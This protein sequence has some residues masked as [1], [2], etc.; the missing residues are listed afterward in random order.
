MTTQVKAQSVP[1]KEAAVLLERAPLGLLGELSS[2]QQ[3]SVRVAGRATARPAKKLY[4][5]R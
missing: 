3:S 2:K 4:A 1:V 5:S